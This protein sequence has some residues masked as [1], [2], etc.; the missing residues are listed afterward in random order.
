MRIACV[1]V[2][3]GLS[4]CSRSAED[5]ATATPPPPPALTAEAIRQLRSEAEIAFTAAS[6]DRAQELFTQLIA[7]EP[8]NEQNY[9]WRAQALQRVGK[10]NEAEADLNR[11]VQLAPKKQEPLLHRSRLA[12][13]QN[14]VERALADCSQ[15][16][17]LGGSQ[18]AGALS[19]RASIYL[20]AR[21]PEEALADCDSAI[22]LNPEFAQAYNNRGL[23]RQALRDFAGAIED[24]SRAIERHRQLG[25][26]YNNR[27][28]LRMQLG[29][30]QEALADLNEAIRLA[31][32]SPNGYDNRSRLLLEQLNDPQGAEKDCTRLIQLVEREAKRTGA[33]ATGPKLA[34]MYARRAQSRFQQQQHASALADCQAA[35]AI[36]GSC[37]AARKLLR[38]VAEAMSASERT[39]PATHAQAVVPARPPSL[40]N[41]IRKP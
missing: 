9:L 21:R 30:D 39:V 10:L 27:G 26:A 32:L 38:E 6:F 20:T 36:D 18:T 40:V 19:Y 35:L 34:V 8:N 22:R 14:Q 15:A 31:P 37:T 16:I 2:C 4:A 41:V 13:A 1:L 28:A 7:A 5:R 3:L 33:R 17:E 24:Y 29:H 12:L 23:A 25:E 11:A